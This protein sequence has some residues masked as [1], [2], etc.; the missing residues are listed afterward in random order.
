MG[1]KAA[2]CNIGRLAL[3][4]IYVIIIGITDTK[5]NVFMDA[6]IS[7][8]DENEANKKIGMPNE[9]KKAVVN[10]N[11]IRAMPSAMNNTPFR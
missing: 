5:K 10:S 9:N 6:V 8:N 1:E 2:F 7:I 11:I 4:I 3:K